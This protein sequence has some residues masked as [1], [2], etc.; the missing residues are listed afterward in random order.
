MARHK[1]GI[2]RFVQ[3]I[4]PLAIAYLLCD[5]LWIHVWNRV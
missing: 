2:E 5:K 1:R 3:W 4:N